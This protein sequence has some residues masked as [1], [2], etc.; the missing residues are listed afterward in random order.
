MVLMVAQMLLGETNAKKKKRFDAC[1]K[2]IGGL[3]R[4]SDH[5]RMTDPLRMRLLAADT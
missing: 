5:G 2:G 1:A 3:T 4:I